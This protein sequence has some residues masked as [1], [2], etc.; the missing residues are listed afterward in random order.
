M[1]V[2]EQFLLKHAI[3]NPEIDI[4]DT[5]LQLVIDL[6]EIW[7]CAQPIVDELIESH[8]RDAIT[9]HLSPGTPSMSQVWLLLVASQGLKAI[10]G[11]REDNTLRDEV[12]PFDIHT[13]FIGRMIQRQGREISNSLI[14]PSDYARGFDNIIGNSEAME[15]AIRDASLYATRPINIV[16]LGE[17]GTGKELFAAAI[18]NSSERHDS[19]FVSLNCGAISSPELINSE[20]FGHTKGSFTGANSD[21]KG[22]FEQAQGGF[23]FLDEIGELPLEAQTK[24][25]RVLQ[26]KKLT[27]V[28]GEHEII[29][30]FRVIAATHKDLKQEVR[31]GRFRLDLYYRLATATVHIPPLRQRDGDIVLLAK[32]FLNQAC[33]AQNIT[34][35][36]ELSAS[37][38]NQLTR[39]DWPGN[40]RELEFTMAR[41]V[42]HASSVTLSKDDISKALDIFPN[43]QDHRKELYQRALDKG[44]SWQEAI[45]EYEGLLLSEALNRTGKDKDAAE[46]LGL[47][48]SNFSVKKKHLAQN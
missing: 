6:E 17:S 11:N 28:G 47:K 5:E 19:N 16:L 42:L 23:V 8:G 29:C 45:A 10:Q 12:L 35:P 4:R 22:V 9:V 31:E 15:E 44:L 43:H 27:R 7:H 26:E 48:P 14:R 24:F 38:L 2:F 39:H 46:L 18:K 33:E 13:D 30:D 21:H 36:L 25:L 41:A 34:P 1:D 20:L 32:F 3:G 37:A 40:V